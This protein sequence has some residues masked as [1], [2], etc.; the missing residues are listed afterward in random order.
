MFVR[1]APYLYTII[2]GRNRPFYP[3]D[4]VKNNCFNGFFLTRVS[5]TSLKQ[6]KNPAV[7]ARLYPFWI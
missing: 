2:G 1:I 3:P 5:K 7:L 6:D 4:Y